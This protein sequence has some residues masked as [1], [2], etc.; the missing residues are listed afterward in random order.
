MENKVIA[1][2]EGVNITE[3]DL[4]NLLLRMP[5]EQQMYLGT[6]QGREKMIEEMVTREL[7]FNYGKDT[8]LRET[9][10]YK[11]QLEAIEKDLLASM[12]MDIEA[13]TVEISDED[14]KKFYEANTAMFTKPETVKASHILVETEEKALEIKKEIENGKSFEEAANDY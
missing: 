8:N 1:T 13:R 2:V 6:E 11:M 9:P 4:Q 14:V 5:R 7:F 12:A 10:E 3:N